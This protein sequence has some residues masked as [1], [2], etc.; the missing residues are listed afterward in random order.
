MNWTNEAQDKD[1]S[2]EHGN[3]TSG[4][5]KCGNILNIWGIISLWKG[6]CSTHFVSC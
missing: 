2:H 1:T 5:T 4:S 6:P 3:R